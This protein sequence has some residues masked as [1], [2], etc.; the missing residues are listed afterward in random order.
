LV[1]PATSA[2]ALGSVPPEPAAS[3]H[4]VQAAE[5]DQLVQDGHVR[6]EASFFWHVAEQ[7]AG[8]LGHR[9]AVPAHLARVEGDHAEDGP[10]G[11][12]L[13]RAV[14]PEEAEDLAG[15]DAERQ[16]VQRD[17]RPEPAAQPD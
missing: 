8:L 16:P 6:V 5:V 1:K 12:G 4:V 2:I 10:H 14:R 9:L 13:A 17:D 11:G 3:R 15:R 7:A